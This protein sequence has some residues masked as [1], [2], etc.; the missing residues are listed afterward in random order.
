VAIEE[1]TTLELVKLQLKI[2]DDDPTDDDRLEP[3]VAAVNVRVRRFPIAQGITGETDNDPNAD[4]PVV[5]SPWP[6]D[7]RQ[8]AT[9]LAARLWKRKNSPAGVEAF[10]AEGAV[11]VRRNDPDIALLL[12]LGDYAKPSVG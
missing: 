7:I 3:I 11:Y 12:D 5:A 4:P 6:P 9:L 10:G 2:A 1:P 8:G